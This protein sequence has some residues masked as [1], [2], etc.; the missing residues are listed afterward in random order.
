M[1]MKWA[2]AQSPPIGYW[3]WTFTVVPCSDPG[4]IRNASGT[5]TSGYGSTF[6]AHLIAVQGPGRV[7]RVSC[8][9]PRSRYPSGAFVCDSV[10]SFEEGRLGALL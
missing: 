10:W 2:D 4:L 6:K 7:A 3:A 9:S 1:F 8:T 5:P